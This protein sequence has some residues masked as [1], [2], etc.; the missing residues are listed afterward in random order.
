MG[1]RPANFATDLGWTATGSGAIVAQQI[2]DRKSWK[3]AVRVATTA[4]V[5]ISTALNAGDTIDGVTLALGDRVLVWQQ[6]TQSQNGV[7]VVDPTPYRAADFDASDEIVGSLVPVTA[8]TTLG[9]KLY[10]NTNTAAVVVDTDAITFEE[11]ASSDTTVVDHGNMGA[12]ET[13]D[14]DAGGTH[15]GVLD[16]NLTLTM[17]GFVTDELG[18]LL[19]GVTQDGTG[20]R[21]I[22][23]DADV[24]FI[25]ND[26]PDLTA[27]AVTWFLFWS[28]EGDTT[29]YGAKIGSSGLTIKEEGVALATLAESLDFVGDGITA[30]GTG[31]AKTITLDVSAAGRHEVLLTED[32]TEVITTE[33][34]LDWLYVW[35]TD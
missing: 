12:T 19:F 27:A 29:I 6:S 8:G 10:R 32:G 20:N 5:T 24:V 35:V 16:A 31:V 17:T 15:I 7:Y 30:S 34:G 18:V 28:V 13:L 23:H 1:N 33:D 22:T 9:G 11:F 21:S 4:S 2:V 25:G 14:L 3:Q 26:Q